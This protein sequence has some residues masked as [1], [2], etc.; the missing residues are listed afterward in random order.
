MNRIITA[1][2]AIMLAL[3][4]LATSAQENYAQWSGLR[5]Y[6]LN[7]TASGANVAVS[8]TNFPVLVRLGAADSAIFAAARPGGADLRF[9]KA[10]GTRLPHQIEHWNA[11]GRAAAV[12]V[13]VDTVRGNS[14]T[15]AL[16]MHWGKAD[17]ADSSSGAAVFPPALGFVGVW[18][19]DGAGDVA[20]ATGSGLTAVGPP[21]SVPGAAAA[22]IIGTARSFNGITQHFSV[23]HDARLNVTAA[24]TMSVWVNASNWDGST[25]LLQKSLPEENNA[26]QYGLRD[27]SNNQLALNLNGTHTAN[28]SPAPVPSTGQWHLI[29]GTY[30]G[31]N[32]I[33]YQNGVP[34]SFG[35]LGDPINTG[36][37]DLKI[38]MRPDGTNFF[39]GML[40]EVR[41]HGVARSAE[42]VALEYENQKPNQTLV[43][44][45]GTSVQAAPR[46]PLAAF[47]VESMGGRVHF[48]L[49]G[50]N[51]DGAL[52][53]AQGGA[54]V[55]VSDMRGRLLWSADM[56]PGVDRLSWNGRDASGRPAPAGVYAARLSLRDAR[57]DV[58]EVFDRKVFIAR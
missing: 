3:A 31:N 13:R 48:R 14:A 47:S 11:A 6:V 12:W 18:H 19:M 30:D 9:T 52:R 56:A 45:P 34:V 28:G 23:A 25:R 21:G 43:Q 5:T 32:V 39:T 40:D 53:H 49:I 4:P 1:G 57:G 35:S 22:G 16:R 7:T 44:L 20:D 15:Q 58:A 29:H 51:P 46:A 8:V 2:S 27:D 24:I 37:G 41:I 55:T 33:Q 38:A 10:D 54:R 17:A 36:T 42:W 50:G 26:G